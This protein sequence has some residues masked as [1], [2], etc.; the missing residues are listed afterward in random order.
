VSR[1]GLSSQ[2]LYTSFS[3]ILAGIIDSNWHVQDESLT[4]VS[5]REEGKEVVEFIARKSLAW[6]AK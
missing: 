5:G 4:N 6:F 3:A 2:R 1:K